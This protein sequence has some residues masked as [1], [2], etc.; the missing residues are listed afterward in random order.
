MVDGVQAI[1]CSCNSFFFFYVK[2]LNGTDLQ[3]LGWN[4]SKVRGVEKNLVKSVIH[5]LSSLDL[6]PLKRH[7]N[8]DLRASCSVNVS[9]TVDMSC[10]RN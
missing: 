8:I 3:A 5:D 9:F 10:P 6:A 7:F 4:R 2:L 1:N